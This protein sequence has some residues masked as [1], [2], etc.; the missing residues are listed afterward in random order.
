MTMSAAM[1]NQPWA[2]VQRPHRQRGGKGEVS[3]SDVQSE[4]VAAAPMPL[5][6][7]SQLP[8]GHEGLAT[9]ERAAILGAA[10]NSTVPAA[11]RASEPATKCK[12]VILRALMNIGQL[13]EPGNDRD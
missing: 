1:C 6:L 7:A 3:I 9:C 8:L 11:T 10:Q 4:G 12:A 13:T 2:G 5:R